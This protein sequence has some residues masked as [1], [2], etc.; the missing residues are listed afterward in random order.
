M[1]AEEA[2][3]AP[4]QE[5]TPYDTGDKLEPRIWPVNH[6]KTVVENFGKVDFDN[7]ESVTA[8]TVHAARNEDRNGGGDARYTLH[9]VNHGV[10]LAVESDEK[11]AVVLAPSRALR[12]AVLEIVNSLN[13]EI[14]KQEAEVFWSVHQ[15][16]VVV[17][18]E[19][20]VRKQQAIIVNESR[21][22]SVNIMSAKVGPWSAG[23][24][25][26]GIS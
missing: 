23:V 5:L 17:P 18:G 15:A 9:I 20:H 13:T 10:D 8:L 21:S 26:T 24:K 11:D 14:E 25:D 22:G 2:A 4:K 7:E 1:T 19:K 12:E 6:G 3:A 16:I